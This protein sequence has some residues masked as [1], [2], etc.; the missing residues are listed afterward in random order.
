MKFLAVK[1]VV[2]NSSI[3]CRSEVIESELEGDIIFT[4]DKCQSMALS[5]NSD[6]SFVTTLCD[7]ESGKSLSNIVLSSELFKKVS[8]ELK[9]LFLFKTNFTIAVEDD[10]IISLEIST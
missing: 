2:V 7:V 10:V 3:C 6:V 4:C 5:K 9:K 8:P 1:E